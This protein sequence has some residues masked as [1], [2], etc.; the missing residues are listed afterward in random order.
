MSG[1]IN[2]PDGHPAAMQSAHAEPS[3]TTQQAVKTCFKTSNF[4][5]LQ[6]H[7]IE[8]FC[9]ELDK[10]RRLCTYVAVV[11]FPG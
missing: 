2:I 9:Q 8:Y 3:N 1:W 7:C 5:I 4:G 11:S 6:S 10:E